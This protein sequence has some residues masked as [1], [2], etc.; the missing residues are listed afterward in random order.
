ML[1]PLADSLRVA[2]RKREF[3]ETPPDFAA[4]SIHPYPRANPRSTRGCTRARGH[5][6][7]RSCRIGKHEGITACA[8]RRIH[9]V[10]FII[11][12]PINVASP[13]T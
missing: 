2:Q 4:K 3:R 6:N 12:V 9:A 10:G 11:V 8:Q 1:P 5:R 7:R 13:C